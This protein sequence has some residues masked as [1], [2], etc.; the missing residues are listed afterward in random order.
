MYSYG[1]LR[2]T[3]KEANGT[4]LLLLNIMLHILIFEID[5][6]WPFKGVFTCQL[7]FCVGKIQFLI[8]YSTM[9]LLVKLILKKLKKKKKKT[10]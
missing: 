10:F 6:T 1:S 5:L 8:S 2:T 7:I 9:T 3:I 4:R